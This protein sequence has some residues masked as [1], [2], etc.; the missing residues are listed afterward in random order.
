MAGSGKRK[1]AE[2]IKNIAMMTVRNKTQQEVTDVIFPNGLTV[3]LADSRFNNGMRINGNAQVVGVINA[4]GPTADFRINGSTIIA[5][6]PQGEIGPEGSIGPP[7]PAGPGGP[8]GPA[9]SIGPAGDD[10]DDGDDGDNST[11][12]GPPGPAGADS[13]VAGP[14]GPAGATIT[15]PPGPPGPAGAGSSQTL[16]FDTGGDTSSYYENTESIIGFAQG[17]TLVTG[18]LPGNLASMPVMIS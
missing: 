6:G 15:G 8:P 14:P 11:V 12:A 18:F 5:S 1:T 17:D 9:G 3:G 13:T 10:G 2:D 16:Y 4:T 7:G